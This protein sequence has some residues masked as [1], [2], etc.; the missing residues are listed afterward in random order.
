MG[1]V[2]WKGAPLAKV[3][4]SGGSHPNSAKC[5]RSGPQGSAVWEAIRILPS[6]AGPVPKVLL[7]AGSH[8]NSA[9][10]RGS[11]PQGAQ[12]AVAVQSDGSILPN[13]LIWS[14]LTTHGVAS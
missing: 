2:T 4:L 7:S 5:R 9:K 8:P 3:L 12:A 6:V 11:G 13:F 10:C 14:P 1:A